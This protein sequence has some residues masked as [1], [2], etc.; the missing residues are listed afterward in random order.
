MKKIVLIALITLTTSIVHASEFLTSAALE[1]AAQALK[2]GSRMMTN[3]EVAARRGS[4][5]AYVANYYK[6]DPEMQH[7]FDVWSPAHATPEAIRA[8]VAAH[9]ALE[10]ERVQRLT[11]IAA[12]NAPLKPLSPAAAH[13]PL[14]APA[15]LFPS[16]E[17][18]EAGDI[19][20]PLTMPPDVQAA[21]E[22]R[23][24]LR[25]A[26]P[27]PI[28]AQVPTSGFHEV[29]EAESNSPNPEEPKPA[30]R[31]AL[32]DEIQNAF[33]TVGD[34]NQAARNI[35]RVFA[36]NPQLR[37]FLQ[38][39]A[40]I[41]KIENM[42]SDRFPQV[43]RI[44][45]TVEKILALKP[46]A[47]D[48][49]LYRATIG[50]T[51]AQY[52]QDYL[53]TGVIPTTRHLSNAY[54]RA[55]DTGGNVA[56]LTLLIKAGARP[57]E[58]PQVLIRALQSIGN[59][60]ILPFKILLENGGYKAIYASPEFQKIVQ[61]EINYFR[62]LSTEDQHK[63]AIGPKLAILNEIKNK[64]DPV[65]EKLKEAMQ[66]INAGTLAQ[67]QELLREGAAVTAPMVSA[68]LISKDPASLTLFGILLESN[69]YTT[70]VNDPQAQTE[71][72]KIAEMLANPR[73]NGLSPEQITLFSE[74]LDLYNNAA[75]QRDHGIIMIPP[76]SMTERFKKLW[77]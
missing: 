47:A 77:G 6:L 26:A 7:N 22:L 72:R 71:L 61:Q 70:I 57:E 14:S 41:T 69:G 24:Q 48:E 27:A 56:V 66:T 13:P 53:N 11:N 9:P 21:M 75:R 30:L 31:L 2:S 46:K 1:E 33:R 39:P 8:A 23:A 42:F 32:E 29:T 38:D 58:A 10:A 37:F 49:A 52:V 76:A 73:S 16:A 44:G 28:A 36:D 45:Y 55:R 40:M 43:A 51:D 60:S 54:E 15:T 50:S 65:Q 67:V 68:A 4:G 19:T 18:A 20:H 34:Y 62:Q 64:W 17:S 59:E 25:K 3:E 63:F 12:Q 35:R 74:K 5:A